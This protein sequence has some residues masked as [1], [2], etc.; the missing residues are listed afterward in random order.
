MLTRSGRT[1]LAGETSSLMDLSL[2]DTLKAL[3]ARMDQ[4]NRQL[5]EF[6]D[7]VDVNCKDLATPLDRLE[8]NR[9]RTTYPLED[10]ESRANS[11]SPWR[12]QAQPYNTED[13]YAQYIKSVKVNA[14]SFDGHLD[15]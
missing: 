3:I 6:K 4:M 1:F 12:R 2:K 8:N 5:Q 15:P 11:R 9:R 10:N 14:L 7:K 13:T